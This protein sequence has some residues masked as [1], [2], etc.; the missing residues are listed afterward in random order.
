MSPFKAFNS[1]SVP[2]NGTEKNNKQLRRIKSLGE[3]KL[4][5]KMNVCG[6]LKQKQAQKSEFYCF[7]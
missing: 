7:C 5:R 1:I 3:K 4:K 2:F 6:K